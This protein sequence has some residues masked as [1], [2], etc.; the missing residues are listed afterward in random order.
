MKSDQTKGEI[1]MNEKMNLLV[2][3]A[4]RFTDVRRKTIEGDYGNFKDALSFMSVT[5]TVID[6]GYDKHT[7]TGYIEYRK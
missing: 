4:K 3:K 6:W 1:K 5:S 2:S 7:M